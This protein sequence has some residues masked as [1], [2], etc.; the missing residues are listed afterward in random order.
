MCALRWL[1]RLAGRVY[2]IRLGAGCQYRLSW[3][4]SGSLTFADGYR[5]PYTKPD[6]QNGHPPRKHTTDN[7]AFHLNYPYSF[8]S[9]VVKF[10]CILWAK[11]RHYMPAHIIGGP[12]DLSWKTGSLLVSAHY[13]STRYADTM[14][15]MPLDPYCVMHAAVNQDMGKNFSAFASLRNILNAHYES[16]AG[17]YMPGIS[18]AAGARVKVEPSPSSQHHLNAL[19]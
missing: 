9:F 4:L 14:N 6:P 16:F 5:I 3:L 11:F 1:C 19:Q 17:Y 12:V 13:E 18:F 2:R 7:L 15:E 10:S 8:V